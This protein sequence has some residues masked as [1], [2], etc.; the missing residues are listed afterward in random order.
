MA[1]GTL[2]EGKVI[3]EDKGDG[4]TLYNKGYYGKPL[5]GGGLELELHEALYLLESNR[6][7]VIDTQGKILSRDQLIKV[8][9]AKEPRMVV[10][11]PVYS[12]MRSRG[13]I[14]KEASKPADFRVFPRGGAPGKTPS[15]YWLVCKAETDKF[16]I[17]EFQELADRMLEIKKTLITGLLD[18][19]GDVTYYN[20]TTIVLN[21]KTDII[22]PRSRINGTVHGDK[23]N[24]DS[25]GISLHEDGFFGHKQDQGIQLSLVE[26]LFMLENDILKVTNG[27]TNDVMDEVSLQKYADKIQ[28]DFPL[29]YAVYRDLRD[30]G[31]IPKTGF[32]YGTAFR[33]YAGRPGEHHAEYMIQP[34]DNDFACSW[35]DVSRAVRVAH[36]VRKNFLLARNT[37]EGIIYLRIKRE[38][39]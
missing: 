19:E 29:R 24:T 9:V 32:K 5:S 30:R 12:E 14:L 11:Y 26:T 28:K 1:F 34:V 6:L 4:N 17:E 31:L 20:I 27:K 39:P 35:Y 23:C 18:E 3:V 21:G 25:D 7:E 16:S 15:Q 2:I 33:C 37:N 36:T 38:T 10:N 13:Y 8:L 22:P